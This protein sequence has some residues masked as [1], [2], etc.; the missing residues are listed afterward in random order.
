MAPK[1]LV[2]GHTGKLGVAV[3]AALEGGYIV[4]GANSA[5]LD[6]ADP[7]AVGA[8]LAAA[9][10]DI[11]VNCIALAQADAC[12]RDPVA[13]FRLNTLLPRFLA[14]K[15]LLDGFGLVHVST[16]VVFSGTGPRERALVESDTPDPI[17][18]YG[19][20]KYMADLEVLR[21][22]GTVLRT[23]VLFGESGPGGQ[24]LETM[25]ARA[26]AG[27]TLRIADDVIVSP[28]Y[29]ADVAGFLMT[30]LPG[31]PAPGLFHVVNARHASLLEFVTKALKYLEI[32]ERVEAA[33]DAEF[34]A[35]AERPLV[36]PLR[37]ERAEP[38][39]SW[40][41]ALRDHCRRLTAG[42]SG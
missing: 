37:S 9:G 22:G 27:E 21:L 13:A 24:F 2:L 33:S 3:R 35:G 39:R 15:G 31:G 5:T 7:A 18:I 26:R 42:I 11:V 6:A 12:E 19:L 10:P 40:R 30:L 41:E 28:T 29:A 17:H 34:A 20:T 38:L 4:T 23:S 16:G 1:V 8:L 14:R 25:I 32:Q 36:T